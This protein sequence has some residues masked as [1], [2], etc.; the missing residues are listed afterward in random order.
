V[1][2]SFV[3]NRF[4]TSLNTTQNTTRRRRTYQKFSGKLL[5]SRTKIE[6]DILFED[7]SIRSELYVLDGRV[8]HDL[9][10]GKKLWTALQP[11]VR[12]SVLESQDEQREYSESSYSISSL[13]IGGTDVTLTSSSIYP[14]SPQ[15]AHSQRGSYGSETLQPTTDSQQTHPVASQY[16]TLDVQAPYETPL[17][18]ARPSQYTSSNPPKLP[19]YQDYS[20]PSV[21]GSPNPQGPDTYSAYSNYATKGSQEPYSSTTRSS[22]DSYNVATSA[23]PTTY[24]TSYTAPDSHSTSSENYTYKSASDNPVS[25][26]SYQSSPRQGGQQTTLHTTSPGENPYDEAEQQDPRSETYYASVPEWKYQS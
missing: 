7:K 12:D 14:P 8:D 2:E 23:Y 5:T 4:A 16:S 22:Y 17:T 10:L 19:T 20:R 24:N 26:S 11:Q 1:K 13:S 21:Y 15:E 25:T 3:S 6:T 18:H 9:V